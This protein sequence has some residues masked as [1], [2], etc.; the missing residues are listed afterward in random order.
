M[1]VENLAHLKKG[2]RNHLVLNENKANEY[3]ERG[4]YLTILFICDEKANFNKRW[5][6]NGN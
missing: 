1:V 2:G 4:F 5:E 6:L 3:L